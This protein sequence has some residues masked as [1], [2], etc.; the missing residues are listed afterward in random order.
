MKPQLIQ[1]DRFSA[2]DFSK[3]A[4][5][6]IPYAFSLQRVEFPSHHPACREGPSGFEQWS[7]RARRSSVL[8]DQSSSELGRIVRLANGQPVT[9]QTSGGHSRGFH[10]GGCARSDIAL[11]AMGTLGKTGWDRLG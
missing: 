1:D 10:L 5:L 7:P 9:L 3:P 4:K 8:E 6:V 11:V 2:T